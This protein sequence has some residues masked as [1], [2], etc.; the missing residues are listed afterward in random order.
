MD[1]QWMIVTVPKMTNVYQLPLKR[2]SNLPLANQLIQQ[3]LSL[4]RRIQNPTR[5]FMS[6]PSASRMALIEPHLPDRCWT[7]DWR[8]VPQTEA[9]LT[10]T[11]PDM[12]PIR[13]R[14]I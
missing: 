5:P 11:A 1:R 4:L 3:S 9:Y 10:L 12:Q 13:V 14:H 6:C 8:D 7:E 2:Y